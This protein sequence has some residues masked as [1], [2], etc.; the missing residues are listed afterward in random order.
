MSESQA[1]TSLVPTAEA[2]ADRLSQAILG[3]FDVYSVYLGVRLG[4]Y[5]SLFVEGS[6]TS[7]ELA[8]RARTEERYTR[9]WLEQ[10]A[11][12]GILTCDSPDAPSLE[13]RFSLPAGYERILLNETSPSPM[14][15][16]A[17]CLAGVFAP[18]HELVA[19]FRSGAGIPYENYGVDMLAGQAGTTR[20]HFTNSLATHWIPAIPEVH[21]RLLALPPAKVAD[22]GVGAGWSSIEIARAYPH[23]EVDGFDLDPASILAAQANAW[24]EGF[25]DRVRFHHRDA[26]DPELPGTYDFALAFECIHDMANPV[27]ALA[28]IRRLI[29]PDG[30]ALIV[31]EKPADRFTPNGDENERTL[32]GFSVF[33]CLPVGR[34]GVDAVATGAV[35]RTET[36]REYATAA[37]FSRIAVLPMPTDAFRFYLLRP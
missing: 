17:Q 4:F 21:A 30:L 27:A 35:M 7:T 25:S 23:V 9:E 1:A 11:V 20:P 31:D 5:R 28:A 8:G 29:E 26:A 12:T 18:L 33:H 19:A 15:A 2:L 3:I 24:Q 16:Y 6:A 22:I 32:Y 10:Q 37:G 36:F 13:R 34:N 14:G